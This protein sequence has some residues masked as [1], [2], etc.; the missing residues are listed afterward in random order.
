MYYYI[1]D[2]VMTEEQLDSMDDESWT[3]Y[4]RDGDKNPKITVNKKDIVY[5]KIMDQAGN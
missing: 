5:G 3:E 4:F 2:A 1:T